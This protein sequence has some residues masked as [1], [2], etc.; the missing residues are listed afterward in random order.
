M[1]PILLSKGA[2]GETAW[3][4]VV[5]GRGA[6]TLAWLEAALS[7]PDGLRLLSSQRLLS[8]SARL[9]CLIGMWFVAASV[10]HDCDHATQG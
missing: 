1:W 4:G 3:A 8:C 2:C 10:F 6:A 7:S 5:A 9:A